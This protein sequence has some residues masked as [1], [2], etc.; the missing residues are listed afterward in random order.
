MTLF[1][2]DQEKM[3]EG[4]KEGR[5]EGKIEV[6]CAMLKENIPLE[7]ISKMTGFSIEEIS[8]LKDNNKL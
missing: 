7:M 8:E 6:T 2:R 4:R 5:K 3:E 1:M